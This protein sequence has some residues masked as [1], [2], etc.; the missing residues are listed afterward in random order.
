MPAGLHDLRFHAPG[1]ASIFRWDV[2][3]AA[4]VTTTI[5]RLVLSPGASLIGFVEIESPRVVPVEVQLVAASEIGNSGPRQDRLDG[6]K[7]TSTT[8]EHGLFQFRDLRPGSYAL[9]ASGEG[10][11]PVVHGPFEVLSGR[12]AVL[13]QPLRMGPPLLL[14]VRVRP[15][16]PPEGAAWIVTADPARSQAPDREVATDPTGTA[17]LEQLS[18]GWYHL[19]LRA[20]V[21]G[22][23]WWAGEVDVQP[24]TPPVWID[25][26]LVPIEGTV[27]RG[28][29][30]VEAGLIFG[31]GSRE[32]RLHPEDG[33]FSAVLPEPGHWEVK[34][35]LRPSA[36]FV[37][38]DPIDIEP[39]TDGGPVPV[40]LV[41]P[42][43]LLRGEVVDAAGR[44]LRSGNVKSREERPPHRTSRGGFRDGR[45][46][47]VGL[48]PGHHRVVTHLGGATAEA[49]VELREGEVTTVRLVLRPPGRITGILLGGGRPLA[50]VTVWSLPTPKWLPVRSAR[51]DPDGRFELDVPVGVESIRL[52]VLPY[53]F[54]AGDLAVDPL[55]AEEVVLEV[56]ELGGTLLLTGAEAG[57]R[58]HREG[59]DLPLPLFSAWAEMHGTFPRQGRWVLPSMAVGT[60]ELCARPPDVDRCDRGTLSAGGTL[61]LDVSA[62]RSASADTVAAP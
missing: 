4:G 55:A 17:R 47:L 58:L 9:L 14:E 36:P 15:P 8:D 44:P 46:E 22:E 41:V 35:R 34:V 24:E 49:V 52:V 6:L 21:R 42:D 5:D 12:E 7:Q 19:E 20:G 32:I 27:E 57:A 38:L 1:W 51:T 40:E 13:A 33:R 10:L 62:P 25:L 2:T 59:I 54:A 23:R 45:F 43:T 56:P 39:A 26:P 3:V 28:G 37:E 50:G 60:Y 53:G 30:P 31:H 29:E 11:A 16:Q 48:P 61:H 18:P